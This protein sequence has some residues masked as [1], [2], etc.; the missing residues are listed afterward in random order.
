ME[1]SD[2]TTPDSIHL[3][4]LLRKMVDE[5]AEFVVMEVSSQSLKLNRVYGLHFE[6]GVFTN[7]SEDHI[8]KN[9]HPD[10]NDYFESKLKLFDLC[11]IAYVNADDLYGQR[12]IKEAQCKIETYG[13]DNHADN[14]AKIL[15]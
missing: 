3:Y 5:G 7:L 10:M 9:E 4:E 1:D 8:S 15:Q 13:I 14:F 2:R 12:V 6:V 11:D